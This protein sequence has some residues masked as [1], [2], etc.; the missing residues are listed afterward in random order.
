MRKRLHEFIPLIAT[1]VC[2][3]M[4]GGVGA[5]ATSS[6]LRSHAYWY[7]MAGDTC[8]NIL[9]TTNPSYDTKVWGT[10]CH[11]TNPCTSGGTGAEAISLVPGGAWNCVGPSGGSTLTV[12][13]TTM[14]LSG[15][16][17]QVK[18]ALNILPTPTADVAYNSHKNTGMSAGSAAGHSIAFSQQSAQL[19]SVSL[20]YRVSVSN[21]VIW[22]NTTALVVTAPPNITGTNQ[23][24]YCPISYQG[25][26]TIT[27]PSGFTGLTAAC[28][29]T[30]CQRV[31]WK[32]MTGSEPTSYT[33]TSG[34]NI[35]FGSGSCSLWGNVNVSGTPHDTTQNFN[36]SSSSLTITAQAPTANVGELEVLFATSGGGMSITSPAPGMR[37]ALNDVLNGWGSQAWSFPVTTA[38]G[39]AATIGFPISS[40]NT[41]DATDVLL[42]G[43]S[44]SQLVETVGGDVGPH[45]QL[46]LSSDG[47]NTQDNYSDGHGLNVQAFGAM[48]D[49]S[50]CDDASIQAAIDQAGGESVLSLRSVFLPGT[51]NASYNLCKPLAIPYPNMEVYGTGIYSTALSTNYDGESLIAGSGPNATSGGNALQYTTALETG[52]GNAL[53][54]HGCSAGN[55]GQINLTQYLRQHING[56]SAFSIEF[57][58]NITGTPG[59]GSTDTAPWGSFYSTIYQQHYRTPSSLTSTGAFLFNWVTDGSGGHLQSTATLSS[60]GAINATSSIGSFAIGLHKEL[61]DYDGTTLRNCL[62]GSLNGTVA[63]SGTLVMSNWEVAMLP[64]RQDATQVLWPDQSSLANGFPGSIDNIRFSNISRYAANSN[65]C[66]TAPSAK[67]T[68]DG[69]TDLLLGFKSCA[70]GSQFCVEKAS[71]AFAQYAQGIAAPNS[72]VWFGIRGN[73]QTN[74]GGVTI[75]DMDVGVNGS[76]QGLLAIWEPN[77]TFRNLS[78][79]GDGEDCLNF[80]DNDWESYFENLK[81]NGSL[82][83]VEWGK[84]TNHP[85]ITDIHSEANW[86]CFNFIGSQTG[87]DLNGASCNSQGQQAIAGIFNG[88]SGTINGWFND[89]ENSDTHALAN[90]DIQNNIAPLIFNGGE[91]DG[92]F[93]SA[94][95]IVIHEGGGTYPVIF[96]GTSFG[97]ST[98]AEIISFLDGTTPNLPNAPDVMIA[99]YLPSGG[100][101]TKLSDLSG[102]STSAPASCFVNVLDSP[103]VGDQQNAYNSAHNA[104]YACTT[105]FDGSR[106]RAS[107]VTGAC[108]STGTTYSGGGSNR[109]WLTCLGASTAW[110]P[111]GEI[112]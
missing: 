77:S 28:Q 50:T 104:I 89:V 25:T 11:A 24:L 65:A 60:S 69:N 66:P 99:P 19:G 56:H 64:F 33:W 76:S 22:N 100:N 112:W 13:N 26:H 101:L 88:T 10:D 34:D 87:I 98:G 41:I 63:G 78:C 96:N 3:F 27:P 8:A 68:F 18:G 103:V 7:S 110:K 39:V 1:L 86:V 32:V 52:G 29:G 79:L 107:D 6:A 90:L 72:T 15:T 97:A 47:S 35:G 81:T 80:Y 12:D 84:A 62:D 70:D 105:A 36:T 108:S 4:L 71:G 30:N 55:C 61:L 73:N 5:Y 82:Q 75:R 85:T 43:I 92:G 23:A 95:P 109:C 21:G 111:T 102:C 17:L 46:G 106:V 67:F 57:T 51:P 37:P 58:V 48:G 14:G 42:K 54:L 2:M 9:A 20:P 38:A 44:G 31:Y 16:T 59:S 94:N 74:A 93:N 53:L 49:G 40:G 91:A 83:G 45:S